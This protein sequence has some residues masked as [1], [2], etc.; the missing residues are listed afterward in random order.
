MSKI[1]ETHRI[2]TNDSY[3]PLFSIAFI[4]NTAADFDNDLEWNESKF[5]LTCTLKNSPSQLTVEFD[6]NNDLYSF[7]KINR[8]LNHY[9]RLIDAIGENMDK[10]I[11][12]ISILSPSEKEMI[13]EN[14]GVKRD[15]ETDSILSSLR[16]QIMENPYQ[17]I[18]S[19]NESSLSYEDFNLKTNSLANYL[20]D[21]FNLNEQDAVVLVANRSIESVLAFY[22]ILKL[23]AVYVPLN[24][25]APKKRIMHIIDDVDAKAVLTNID[26]DLENVVVDL[27]QKSLYEYDF[28]FD[29][30]GLDLSCQ[31]KLSILHTSGTTGIPKGVQISHENIESFLIS[32]QK[33]FYDKD[34]NVFYHTTNIG[35]D[36][37]L[38]EIIFSLLNGIQLH[39]IDENYDFTQIPKDILNQKSII[40]TVPF[41]LKMFFT[42]PNFE[43]IMGNLGQL[44]LAGEALSESLVAEIRKD[45]N[46]VIFNAYGPCEATIFASIKKVISDKVT[47]GKA[48][49]NTQIYILNDE[50]QLCPIGIPGELCI[51]GKQL[52]EGYINQDDETDKHFISNPFDEGRLYCTGDLAYLDENYEINFIGR[53]DSQI[54][55]NGQRIEI[56]EINRQIEKNEDII[57]AVTV[58]NSSKTQLHSYIV[59]DRKIDT[60]KLL[61]DLT[62]VLLPFMLPSSIMQIESIPINKN[63]KIDTKNLPRPKSSKCKYLSPTNDIEKVIVEI[64]ENVLDMDRVGIN[65]NFYRLG[66]DSIKAIRIVS[67]LQNQNISC[68]PRDILNYK[69]PYLIAQNIKD[70]TEYSNYSNLK[71]EEEKSSYSNLKGEEEKSNYSNLKDKSN[72]YNSS[73]DL[74]PI[75][76]YFFDQINRNDYTQEFILESTIDLDIDLLQAALDELT[77]LHEMLRAKFTLENGKHMQKIMPSNMQICQIN[78]FEIADD[79]DGNIG[80]IIRKSKDSLDVFNKLIYVSLLRYDNKS[81]LIFVIHHLIVDGVSWSIILDDL[82]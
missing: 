70:K 36:T 54:K 31:G 23:N 57:Q 53:K 26:L 18:L 39:I 46:P 47:I 82:T 64:W 9:V 17:I 40:N 49:I 24:P 61:N 14:S 76:S 21:N 60:E 69:T 27:G 4:Q 51:G 75:Q 2:T 32:A 7:G 74:L 63:G 73:F 12:D 55:I 1:I 25:T 79:F 48:N 15:F 71:G 37:H 80:K 19:D 3:N 66:G 52:S 10:R 72:D 29:Y 35:F 56:D 42:L 59:S 16:K 5:D 34:M 68:N 6:Y 67:L 38:F 44:I 43:N 33:E 22:S 65:D 50:K 81:Y 11:S 30:D 41:K 13:L 58:A 78:E 20:K 8:L 45:Y 62:A 77:N 28:D